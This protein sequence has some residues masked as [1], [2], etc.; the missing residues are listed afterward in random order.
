[1][2]SKSADT[3]VQSSDNQNVG[4]IKGIAIGEDGSLSYLLTVNG[5]R[6]VAVNPAAMSLSYDDTTDKWNANVDAT[7][8]Q[9]E[10][11]AA[12]S[13]Q[14]NDAGNSAADRCLE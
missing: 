13:V 9:I 2:N 5:G 6:D 3:N 14:S 7:K 4:T 10:L 8:Q 1:M 11:G 12:G